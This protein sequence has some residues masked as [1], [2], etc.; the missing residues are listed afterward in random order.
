MGATTQLYADSLYDA[1]H[2]SSITPRP[3]VKKKHKPWFDNEC[4]R[5]KQ[6]CLEGFGGEAYPDTRRQYKRIIAL[7]KVEFEE[8][9]LL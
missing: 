3:K 8:K 2:K 4:R 6:A 7:K 1:L 9:E 5:L